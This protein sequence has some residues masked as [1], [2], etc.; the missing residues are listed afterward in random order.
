M[1]ETLSQDSYIAGIKDLAGLPIDASTM[2][3]DHAGDQ[4][5]RIEKKQRKLA[6]KVAFL[7]EF[8]E[9]ASKY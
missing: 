9:E 2:F 4:K 1:A 8:L 5:P 7:K 6:E 3:A